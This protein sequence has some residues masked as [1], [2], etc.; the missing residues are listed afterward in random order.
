MIKISFSGKRNNFLQLE[1]DSSFISLIREN[2]SVPNP[3]YRRNSPFSQP[4]L[5]CITPS[6]KFEIGLLQEVNNFILKKGILV[7]IDEDIKK[8]IYK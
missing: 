2:F 3:A 6:G 8:I 4:R 1:G 5:Y 7:V